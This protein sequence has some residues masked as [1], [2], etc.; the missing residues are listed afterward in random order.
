[1]P[2][3]PIPGR[4][5]R[6]PVPPSVR[7]PSPTLTQYFCVATKEERHTHPKLPKL[8]HVAL[9]SASE[10]G[11]KIHQNTQI[12]KLNFKKNFWWLC[13]RPPYRGGATASPPQTPPIRAPALRAY[14]A[15]LAAF[16]PSIVAPQPE[17]LDPPLGT[18]TL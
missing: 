12:C 6:Y 7:D 10:T 17:I 16:G 1:M 13:P 9:N 5:Y 11:A 3:D 2:P 4:G 14:R 8:E 15:S 18:P